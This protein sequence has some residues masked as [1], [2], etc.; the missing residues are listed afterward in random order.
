MTFDPRKSAREKTPFGAFQMHRS[1]LATGPQGQTP[2]PAKRRSAD[3]ARADA[4]QRERDAREARWAAAG[5]VPLTPE[6]TAVSTA[7]GR[8]DANAIRLWA[9]ANDID[10]PAMGPLPRAVVEAHNAAKEI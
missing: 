8:S 9:W 2:V 3:Q 10:C 5:C 7:R 4:E 6:P 1:H